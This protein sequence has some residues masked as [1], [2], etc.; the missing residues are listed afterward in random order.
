MPYQWLK[1]VG[2]PSDLPAGGPPFMELNVS[3]RTLR[4]LQGETFILSGHRSRPRMTATVEATAGA[5]TYT[6]A[7]FLSGLL[8]RDPNGASRTDIFP[9]AASLISTL[10]LQSE[11]D[12]FILHFVNT[13]DAA[14][15]VTFGGAPTGVTY[16]NAAQTFAQNESGTILIVRT[17]PTTVDV[18]FIG[19]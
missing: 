11:G 15:V 19:A 9:D 17:S 16:K 13:A 8:A 1:I 2:E 18:Y 4:P 6:A 12:S 3:A 14:E 7:Q 10:G 5:V